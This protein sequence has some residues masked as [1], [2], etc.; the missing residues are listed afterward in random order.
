MSDRLRY[1]TLVETDEYTAQRDAILAK[2]SEDVIGGPLNGLLWG[3]ATNPDQYDRATANIYQAVSRVFGLTIPV[4]RI[5]F[6]IENRGTDNEHVL[7]LWIEEV[8]EILRSL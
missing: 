8:E 1:R 6:G 5:F 3:I 4:L 2:Y 7:L